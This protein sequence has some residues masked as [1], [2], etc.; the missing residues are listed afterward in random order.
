MHLIIPL[1]GLHNELECVTNHT[2]ANVIRQLSSLSK[3]AEDMFFELSEETKKVFGRAI[4][5]QGRIEKVQD[6]VTKLNATV[7][8][9]ESQTVLASCLIGLWLAAWCLPGCLS[10]SS[11]TFYSSYTVFYYSSLKKIRER[12]W[13]LKVD[14]QTNRATAQMIHIHN[15]GL[16]YSLT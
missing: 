7:E 5:L 15:T 8:E 14:V 2:L 11:L 1:Q 13:S 12:D 9:G 3:M 16:L 6:K 10:L 4:Q